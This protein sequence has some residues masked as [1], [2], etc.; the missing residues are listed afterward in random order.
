MFRFAAAALP[1]AVGSVLGDAAVAGVID[2]H[3]DQRLNLA[4]FNGGVGVLAHLPGAA[5]DE[6]CFRIEEILAVVHVEDRIVA[7]GMEIVAGRNVDDQVAS[8][9]EKSAV[10]GAMQAKARMRWAAAAP[11]SGVGCGLAVRG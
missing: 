8:V 2:A 4:G 3:N 5:A 11:S 6:R 10:E 1:V 9:G 7:L